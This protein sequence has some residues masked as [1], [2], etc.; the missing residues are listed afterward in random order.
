MSKVVRRA[1]P[2]P[3]TPWNGTATR[4]PA[5]ASCCTTRAGSA[6]PA[7]RSRVPSEEPAS[8][9]TSATRVL[10]KWRAMPVATA[11]RIPPS[12]SALL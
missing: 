2:R 10:E 5:G 11:S 1:A 6:V 8:A 7:T 9:A 3:G 12:V 4:S